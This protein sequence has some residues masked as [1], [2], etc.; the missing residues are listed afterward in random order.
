MTSN[1]GLPNVDQPERLLPEL[2]RVVSGTL[3]AISHFV[4]GGDAINV[5]AA[6]DAGNATMLLRG[7]ALASFAAAGWWAEVANLCVGRAL[8]TARGIVIEGAGI[9]GFPVAET[10]LEWGVLVAR[11]A[12]GA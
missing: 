10:L 12:P 8:P 4:P 2:R 7:E 11:R 6:R 1:L 3:L 9:D 5:A